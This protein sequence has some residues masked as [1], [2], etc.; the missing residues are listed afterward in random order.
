[1]NLLSYKKDKQTVVNAILDYAI[2]KNQIVYGAR[3]TNIQLP[4]HLQKETSDYDVLAKNPERAAKELVEKLNLE[5]GK[6][7]FKVKKAKYHKTWK[8]KDIETG[9]TIVDYTKTVGRKP[10]TKNVLGVKY[11]DIKYAKS[12]LKKIL[13]DEA[14]KFRH[15]KDIE[16]L[17][18]IKK[19]EMEVW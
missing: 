3:S 16:T 5:Y 17:R 10:K 11:A 8:V 19:G 14:S 12:K 4:K 18:R 15:D 9:K 6:E 2:K 1:M 7:K 13:K